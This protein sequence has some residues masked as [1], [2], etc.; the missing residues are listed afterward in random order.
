M[1][2]AAGIKLGPYEV[3]A[4]LGAGGMGEVYRAK[5]TRLGREVAVKVLPQHLSSEPEVRARFERE[6]RTVSALNHPHICTLFDVGS[7]DGVDYLVME[8]LEG[9]TLAARLAKGALGPAEVL[10]LGSQIADA[11]DRAH[12][13]GIVHRDLK[14]GNVMLT[15][16]GAKLMDFGLARATGLLGPV[17]SGMSRAGLTQSPTIAAPLTAEGTIL[18]TFQYMSPEQLEGR[19]ADARSDL[20]ALGCVLYEMACGRRAFEG[21]S[22]ATLIAAII[23]SEPPPISQVA[24]LSPPALDRL[25]ARCLAKDPDDR[26]QTAR[27]LMHELRAIGGG[28]A[29]VTGASAVSMSGAAAVARRDGRPGRL[30]WAIAAAALALGGAIGFGLGPALR[31]KKTIDQPVQLSLLPHSGAQMSIYGG[32]LAISPD[33]RSVAYFAVDSGKP[34][35]IWLQSLDAPGPTQLMSSVGF[36]FPFWAPDGRSVGIMD[37]GADRIFTVRVGEGSPL[38]LCPAAG[39]RGATWNRSGVIVFA[40]RTTGPLLRISA[41]GGEPV[42]VSWPDPARHEAAHRFPWFLP[43]GEHFLFVS[44]PAGPEG[45][46]VYAGSLGSREVTKIMTAG[47]AATYA[48]PGYLLFRRSGKVMAQRFDARALKVEGDPVALADAPPVSDMDAEP[49]AQASADGRLVLLDAR[50]AETQLGWFDRTGASHETLALPVGKW[51]RPS[52]SPDDRFAV[53]ANGDDL[54]RVDLARAVAT[55]LTAAAGTNPEPGVWSPDGSRIAFTR[56]QGREEIFVM[57]ADG[58]G[59]RALATTPDLFKNPEDWTRD[60]LL[61]ASIAEKTGRD[62]WL[63]PNGD[64][65]KPV[66]WLQTEFGEYHG[67]VSPDGHWCAYL[68]NEAGKDDVYIQ[69][70]PVAGHKVRVSTTG[71]GRV[72]WMPGGDEV[73]FRSAGGKGAA[74]DY[75]CAS[76]THKGSDLEVGEPRLL[77][78]V[79]TEVLGSDFSHDG[80]R[81]LTSITAP[82]SQTGTI[83]VILDWTALLKR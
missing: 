51:G 2:L 24:P 17:G 8:L 42:Q 3:L 5:D 37:Q 57:S 48:E 36:A 21:R 6:A 7:A 49:V 30:V 77:F 60:G 16:S 15:K 63:V 45:F 19:E 70:F 43:D 54:W 31:P 80:K 9:E 46:D 40:P 71:A 20:W 41:S 76:V 81:L 58:S 65:S 29:S 50:D 4:P 75:W 10:R 73:C 62:L 59:E 12:R 82:G 25:V 53:V 11:L 68:S 22:Q 26:W 34:L 61:I 66:P 14:P 23:Q 69:S 72:W 13:A 18:G 47:S 55:R 27:D 39:P 56:N 32:A 35:G 38:T 44:L 52:L 28:P 33:G 83:R 74:G 78:R 1:S 79:P 67:K 64:G